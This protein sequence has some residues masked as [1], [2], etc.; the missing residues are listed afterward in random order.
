MLRTRSRITSMS[1]R[2]PKVLS[3]TAALFFLLSGCSDGSDYSGSD[4]DRGS[5]AAQTNGA[6]ALAVS[7]V[8]GLSPTQAGDGVLIATHQGLI[9]YA[10]GRLRRVGQLRSDMMGFA[11]GSGQRLYASGHPGESEDGPAALGL[12]SSADAGQTWQ[13]VSL[14]GQVDFHALDAWSDGVVGYDGAS[15]SLLLSEDEGA[16]WSRLPLVDPVADLAVSEDGRLVATTQAG[17]QVSDDGGRSFRVVDGAPTLY[18]VDFAEDGSLVGLDIDGRAHVSD[19]DL[20]SWEARGVVTQEMTA[21]TTTPSGDV[22]V[23]TTTGLVRSRDDGATFST[24]VAW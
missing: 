2:R 19:D 16:S 11:A 6:A 12:I 20:S 24:A 15:S 9:T 13:S 14:T 10:D 1:H 22:W 8:H 4:A 21:M 5:T 23:S 18:L 17:L 7:H 3:T